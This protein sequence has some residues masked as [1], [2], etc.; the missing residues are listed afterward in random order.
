MEGCEVEAGCRRGRPWEEVRDELLG[1][2]ASRTSPWRLITDASKQ[3]TKHP[4]TLREG[5]GRRAQG[6]LC[7]KREGIK[8]LGS[9]LRGLN[10]T[11][12]PGWWDREF[13]TKRNL[14]NGGR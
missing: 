12:G 9:G 2:C 8:F 11:G 3:L 5:P 1:G 10:I 7:S 13:R 4:S 6:V 14:Q